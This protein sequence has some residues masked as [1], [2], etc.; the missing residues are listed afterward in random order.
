MGPAGTLQAVTLSES[1]VEHFIA[2]AKELNTL[3]VET[4]ADLGEDPSKARSYLE[5]LQASA[6]AMAILRKHT[7]DG[8]RFQQVAT[9]VMMAFAAEEM[10]KTDV[11]MKANLEQ[12]K[13]QLPKEQYEQMKKMTEAASANMEAIANQ[14]QSNIDLV[15]KYRDQ[16]DALG[17]K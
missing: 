13:A 5:G 1:D 7:F 14:P 3:G 9:S 12:M 17:K 6:E 10:K 2:A 4:N 8:P 11:D 15:A 16:I